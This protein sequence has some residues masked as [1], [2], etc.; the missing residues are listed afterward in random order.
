[1]MIHLG[2]RS[3]LDVFHLV[4]AFSAI[5][6]IRP[7]ALEVVNSKIKHLFPLQFHVNPLNLHLGQ[8]VLPHSD[9]RSGA[10][11]AVVEED[12]PERIIS[13]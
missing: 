4:F 1:M 12:N 2:K 7:Y 9:V 11:L 6:D 5:V 13:V 10:V 8:S 3:R